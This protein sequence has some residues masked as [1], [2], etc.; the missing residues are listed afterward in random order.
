MTTSMEWSSIKYT[1]CVEE[2]Q[3]KY[4]SQKYSSDVLICREY[5]YE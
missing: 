4:I 1:K 2:N 5:T 3:I